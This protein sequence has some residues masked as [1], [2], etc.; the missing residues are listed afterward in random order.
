M[1]NPAALMPPGLLVL[2]IAA[3]A[4]T[5]ARNTQPAPSP[6]NTTEA[7]ITPED[8]RRRIF[9]YA[10]DSMQGRMAGM[11]GNLRAVEYIA[12]EL[13]RLGL[14]PAGQSG[15]YFQDVPMVSRLPDSS[16]T[17]LVNGRRLDLWKDFGAFPYYPLFRPYGPS[18]EAEGAPTVYAGTYGRAM[19]FGPEGARGKVVIYGAPLDS[20]GQPDAQL[21]KHGPLPVPAGA[22]AVAFAT[23]DLIPREQISEVQEPKLALAA[24]KPADEKPVALWITREVG[25]AIFGIPLDRV[26]PGTAGHPLGGRVAFRETPSGTPVRN[27]VAVLRGADPALG[28]QYVALGAHN[29]HLGTVSPPLQHDSVFVFNRLFRQTG[30]EG[31]PPTLTD[32]QKARFGAALDSV[33]RLRPERADSI[34]NG[35]DDD[36]SGSMALLEIAEAMSAAPHPRRSILF[37]WH[38]AEEEGLFG[39]QWFTEH[40]TVPRES[41]VAQLNADMIGRGERRDVPEGGPR[42][43]LVVGSR[44]LSRELGDLAETVAREPRHGFSLDYKYDATGHPGQVYCRSDHYMYARF[45]IPVAFFTTDIHQDYHQVTDEPQYLSYPKY[46]R[47]TE[48]LRDLAVRLAN[49][50]QPPRVDRPKPDPAA[51]CKQ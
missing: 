23:Y 30:D 33:R 49:R 45:G 42:Y 22:L 41:I 17:L 46:A 38:A 26:K 40:P 5:S 44:R 21:R 14:Q 13:K 27:V 10:D 19:D 16:S 32:E 11:P 39:S 1:R 37:V 18:F 4:A 7:A 6:G 50:E 8:L 15:G 9:I 20:A 24:S 2:G 12:A 28:S 31:P 48:F 29:D 34:A 43:L 3:C 47:V 51:P 25:T 36:G 35:A